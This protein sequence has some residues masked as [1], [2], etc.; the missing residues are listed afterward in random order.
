MTA[1]KNTLAPASIHRAKK[2]H[3]TKA[4]KNAAVAIETAIPTEPVPAETT[5]ETPEPTLEPLPT[6]T[7]MPVSA[8]Q[9]TQ[10]HTEEPTQNHTEEPTQGETVSLPTAATTRLSALDAALRVL[11]ESGQAMSCQE[12]IAAMIVNNYWSSPKGRTPAATLYACFLREMKTK[13]EKARM[14]KTTRGKFALRP[15]M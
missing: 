1:K 3:K 7:T 13:G 9:P 11:A 12:L 2:A 5:E 15:S 6:A 10:D 14:L 8:E 4:P